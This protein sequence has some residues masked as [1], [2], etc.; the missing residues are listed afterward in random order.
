MHRAYQPS[1]AVF[2]NITVHVLAIIYGLW[3]RQCVDT[4]HGLALAVVRTGHDACIEHLEKF[5]LFSVKYDMDYSAI[6]VPKLIAPKLIYYDQIAVRT[7]HDGLNIRKDYR[8]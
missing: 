2:L 8:Y 4:A 3:F 1:T 6:G 7:G 5:G